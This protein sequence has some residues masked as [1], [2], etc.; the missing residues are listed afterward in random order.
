M[1]KLNEKQKMFCDEYLANGY[2]ATQA[3]RDVYG[4]SNKTPDRAAHAL[5]IKPHVQEYIQ[6]RL[7]EK[8]GPKD[9]IIQMMAEK[10]KSV[11][12]TNNENEKIGM[13]HQLKAVELLG[14]Q[15]GV[16]TDKV[17]I[18]TDVITVEII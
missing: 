6:T 9:E 7:N 11:A 5:K 2:N 15:Y 17:E 14:K 3:Y 16:Y 4:D 1:P 10:L 18:K 8:V 12:F 13:Q